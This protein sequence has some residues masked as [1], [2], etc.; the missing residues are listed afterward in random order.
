M[1]GATACQ[2]ARERRHVDGAHETTARVSPST[3]LGC[4]AAGGVLSLGWVQPALSW[5]CCGV[6]YA[7]WVNWLAE[8]NP[9][10]AKPLKV[11]W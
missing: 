10:T 1:H 2:R 7:T 8:L 11:L 3:P 4:G 6:T 9:D 5:T